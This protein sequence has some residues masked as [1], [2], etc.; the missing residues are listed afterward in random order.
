MLDIFLCV[1]SRISQAVS[2][3]RWKEIDSYLCPLVARGH[4]CNFCYLERDLLPEIHAEI[5][6][7]TLVQNNHSRLLCVCVCVR[8]CVWCVYDVSDACQRVAMLTA[9]LHLPD[10]HSGYN[11]Q[12]CVFGVLASLQ[13]LRSSRPSV[14]AKAGP[15]AEPPSSSSGT[16]SLT[17]C[18]SS[19]APC[20]CGAR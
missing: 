18:R 12:R 9:P 14:R 1:W 6:D 17:V 16:T 15:P 20:W 13:P 5:K 10:P 4:N 8:A 2:A 3:C 19:S 11:N 7:I